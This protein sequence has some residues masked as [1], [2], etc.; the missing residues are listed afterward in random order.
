MNP[1]APLCT[2]PGCVEPAEGFVAL[3]YVNE[4]RRWLCAFHMRPIRAAL[5][6]VL[7]P[8]AAVVSP[9]TPAAGANPE[10]SL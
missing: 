6:S 4:W 9:P 3:A 5:V 2:A 7:R 8:P 1:P 10:A